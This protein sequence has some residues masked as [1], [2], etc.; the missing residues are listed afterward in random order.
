MAQRTDDLVFDGYDQEAWV[1]DQRYREAPWAD[2]VTL[3]A[4][5]N[6]HLARVMAAVPA[7]VLTRPRE[8]HSLDRIAWH[9]TA[10]DVPATLDDLMRDY[11]GHV[12]HH[13]AQILGQGWAP[14]GPGL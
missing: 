10:G 8:H 1:A 9:P 2:L 4:S 5:Y 14:A 3:W 11:V 12:N 13:L 6:R 7:D